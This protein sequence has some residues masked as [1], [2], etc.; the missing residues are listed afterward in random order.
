[1]CY[2]FSVDVQSHARRLQQIGLNAYESRAYLT[3]IGHPRFKALDLAARAHVPRQ[4]IY[5]VMGSLVEKGFAQVVHGKAKLFSAVEPQLALHGYL[6]RRRETLER[7][8]AERQRAADGLTQD[9]HALFLD[10]SRDRGPLDYLRIVNEPGQI[11]EEYRRLLAR[12]STE[13]LEFSRRPYAVD[14]VAEPRVREA[15][16]RGAECRLMFEQRDLDGAHRKTL[17]SLAKAGALIRVAEE[18]PLKLALFDGR[19]GMI[20][21]IDPILT[22]PRLTALVFEHDALASAL[23]GLFQDHWD[24]AQEL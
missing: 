6:T 10:G 4:K 18:L 3:L 15:L 22:R 7:E 23:R 9:L 17:R 19:F 16:G 2:L 1:V 20:A 11:A 8:L 13:Y 21:L 5:E 12:S 24:R 14:P